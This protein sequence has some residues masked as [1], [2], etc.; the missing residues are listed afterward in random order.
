LKVLTVLGTRPE[1][2]K[3]SS[4]IPL[5][6]DSVE[7]VLVHTGQHYSF[8]MDSVFFH[9][10][11]LRP[12]D[13]TLKI[14][15]QKQ[16]AQTA[17]IMLK[18][19]PI[20]EKEQ[21]DFLVVQGD[22]NST[23]AGGLAGAKTGVPVAHVEA[24]CRSFNRRMPEEVNRILTDHCSTLLFAP[25]QTS[26]RH[27]LEE[28]IAEEKIHLVGNTI[29]D[30]CM[31]SRE[32]AAGSDTLNRL[33]LVKNGYV[34]ATM[35]RAE[36]TDEAEALREIVNALDD[37]AERIT[38]VLPIHPRTKAALKKA[39]IKLSQEM[40]VVEPLG[41]LDFISLLSNAKFAMTDSGGVQEEAAILD[42]P[43]LVM[44]NETEW[45]EYIEAGKN[46]L[47]GTQRREIAEIAFGLID[48]PERLKSLRGAKI[49]IKRDVS[50]KILETLRRAA[51]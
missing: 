23:L 27:L 48:D 32:L 38:L 12:A 49:A 11:R 18:L 4:L 36:N 9:E 42:T 1:I 43:A 3:L 5:L 26:R 50:L 39:G 41:Y 20:L 37:V 6:D 10:L 29:I 45:V 7:H 31:R 8:E 34:L 21:P 25:D 19:E 30:A 47:A 2:I 16:I 17:G 44:R 22:T 15:S 28:G 24:G 33:G 40:K 35:H 14:G 46:I 51:G 13:Y